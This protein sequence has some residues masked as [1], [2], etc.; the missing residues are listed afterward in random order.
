MGLF[1]ATLYPNLGKLD[2]LTTE[3]LD[4]SEAK[5]M[6]E[7]ER[8]QRLCEMHPFYWMETYGQI[9]S[10]RVEGKDVQI[11]PF[12]LNTAQLILANR[13][14]PYLMPPDWKRAK[15][16]VLKSRKMGVSTFFAALDYWFMR[17][18]KGCGAFIIAD[19]NKH[20]E[21]IY[22][23]VR[24]L[25]EKDGLPGKPTGK[26]IS[27]NKQGLFLSNR[28]TLEMDS[29]ETK[30]PATS[31]TVQILHM[32]VDEN[33]PVICVNGFLL[34]AKKTLGK[35]IVSHNL[36]PA[37][38][39]AH[40]RTERQN[41]YELRIYGNPFPLRVTEDHRLFAR[42]GRG[43]SWV[44]VREIAK[45][46]SPKYRRWY[47]GYPIRPFWGTPR[48]FRDIPSTLKT[49]TRPQGG[50]RT[51]ELY[52]NRF[53]LTRPM[54]RLVGWYLAEGSIGKAMGRYPA[55]IALACHAAEV[56]ML[57]S[58]V[59]E[60]RE[61]TIQG[62]PR[63]LSG[64][65]AE[66]TINSSYWARV[67]ARFF[68]TKESK[69][70][71]DWV[72]ATNV[73]FARGIV[74]GYIEGD[75]H[76]VQ[77]GISVCISS[78]APQ[79]LIQL[80]ELLLSLGLGYSSL[81]YRE[82][83]RW[84]N[85]NCKAIWTLSMFGVTGQAIRKLIGARS[86]NPLQR[87]GWR[88][89]GWH[90]KGSHPRIW[91]P[92]EDI[93]PTIIDAPID[94]EVDHCLH[95]YMLLGCASHNSENAKWP[96]IVD[97][98]TSLLNS[99]SREG[100]VWLVK[101]STACGINK[102]KT[103][104]IAAL[105]KRS[106]WEFIFL[107]WPDM[108]DCALTLTEKERENMMLSGEEADLMD[109]F[110]ISLENIKFRREKIAEIGS[111]HFKQDFPL[112]AR[113]PFDVSTSTYFDPLKIEDRKDDIEF[114]RVW[115]QN[116]YDDAMEQFPRVAKELKEFHGG[117]EAYLRDLGQRCRL[118]R[119]VQVGIVKNHVTFT[120]AESEKEDAGQVLMW[121]EPD[122]RRRYVVTVDPAEG[123]SSDGY[124]SDHSVIEVFDCYAR[125]QAAELAGVYDEEITARYAVLLARLYG[126]AMIAV[127]MNCKCGGAVLTYIKERYK[128]FSLYRRQVVGRSRMVTNDEGWRTTPGNKQSLCYVLKIHFKEDDCVLHSVPLLDEMANFIEEK[129]KLR[130]A[131]N[132]T[133]DRVMACAIALQI[134]DSTPGLRS[135][136]A[137]E[138]ERR[139]LGAL[140]RSTVPLA[141]RHLSDG[142]PETPTDTSRRPS[143]RFKQLSRY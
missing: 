70:I 93:K 81:R 102:W 116:G 45:G 41:G 80:R 86:A 97:A 107:E 4:S 58:I 7:F 92:I 99:V 124:T 61:A 125:E 37:K 72:W 83:G 101:E 66:V 138:A 108:E 87:H 136:K 28:S 34:P 71:P 129:G 26:T 20:T 141:V 10:S 111:M 49:R 78:V 29:G 35:R 46:C 98:E 100:F 32:C 133:D 15:L 74:Q 128:Y 40:H 135:L 6:D 43:G 9:E 82:G 127:E 143:Q 75:G 90:V 14:A 24:L 77:D 60:V 44:T 3:F 84:Y 94:L 109:T 22:N 95:S 96:Q 47:V 73:D 114:Y 140:P 106:S 16:I 132:H 85:R 112:H 50:G 115:K 18:I 67:F 12:H 69:R 120:P 104:C 19:K 91:L 134:I 123:I 39:I 55:K 11:I 33:T 13:C 59:S 139:I 121:R 89:S 118:F 103:D 110:G 17:N 52:T 65:R 131:V 130:A 30:H 23:M 119:R 113:E 63:Q 57:Y 122:R 64:Q 31:Q 42:K 21:N 105:E 1:D 62:R 8:E 117:A 56:E 5:G 51:H 38:I 137:S 142:I 76:L 2:A 68:G 25:W 36:R 27:R 79:L 126:D 53:P 88:L 48:S 54:G